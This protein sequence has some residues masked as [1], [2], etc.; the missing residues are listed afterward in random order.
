[1]LELTESLKV[2]LKETAE[3]LQGHERRRFM[4]QT[5]KELGRGGQRLAERE[6]GWHRDLIRKGKREVESG[7]VCIDGFKQR[8]RKTV[9]SRLPHLLNDIQAIVDSQSQTDPKFVTNRLYTRLSAAEVRRQLVSQKGYSSEV[10]PS[11]ETIRTRLN[12]L[13]YYP[14]KV[15]KTKPQKKFP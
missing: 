11:I 2:L 8:G 4:A 12:Q 7:V 10:L 6:L 9:E 3:Q 13:G 14:S 1:M 15:G 5:V